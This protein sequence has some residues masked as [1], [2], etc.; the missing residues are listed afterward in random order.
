MCLT[1]FSSR[2]AIGGIVCVF[3]LSV[4][5][6]ACRESPISP[7]QHLDSLIN[8][9][10]TLVELKK[11]RIDKRK[12]QR[13][14]SDGSQRGLAETFAFNNE[15]IEEYAEFQNDSALVYAKRNIDIANALNDREKLLDSKLQTMHLLTKAYL[16]DETID[17]AE[18]LDTNTLNN[19]QRLQYYKIFSDIYLFK[20]EFHNGSPY[21]EIF[22]QNLTNYRLKVAQLTEP[23]SMLNTI[24]QASYLHDNNLTNEAI[25]LLEREL[26]NYRSGQR[27]FSIITGT[28]AYYYSLKG[29]AEKQKILLAQSAASD[30]E[31]C[32]M[33]NS[34]LRQLAAILFDEGDIDRAYNYIKLSVAD[35]N[36]YGTRLRNIQASQ[37]LPRIITA[38]QAKQENDYNK[39]RHATLW[40]AITAL[41]LIA[42]LAAFAFLLKKYLRINESRRVIINRLN[43][44]IEQLEIT[45]T[46]LS[47]RE[48]IKEQ[49]LGRFLALSSSLI[50]RTETRRKMLNRFAMDNKLSELKNALKSLNFYYESTNMFYRNF[51]SAFLNIYPDFIEQVNALLNDSYRFTPKDGE[52]LTTELRILAL[53]RLDISDNKEIAAILRSSITTVYTYLSKIKSHARDKNTFLQSVR[54]IGSKHDNV[55]A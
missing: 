38:Y 3:L 36:F 30:I 39:L 7:Y 51:D 24:Y 53:I 44:T 8:R 49:Y 42:G 55:Q 10:N 12:A 41:M 46:Q 27:G 37:L 52:Q 11:Q 26:K 34:S 22:R 32:F 45:N 20:T 14:Q 13:S 23:G 6:L 1:H 4:C 29:D 16:L 50:D 5:A 25:E 17:I 21:E 40:I 48:K 43:D 15:L 31:G 47:E 28:L 9:H 19:E 33:E 2:H 54:H 18:Q 35:A